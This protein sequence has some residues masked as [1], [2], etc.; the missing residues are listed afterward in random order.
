VAVV[1]GP[2]GHGQ[3][4]QLALR[5]RGV[6]RTAATQE[7]TIVLPRWI[8]HERL[9]LCSDGRKPEDSFF[10]LYLADCPVRS[11]HLAGAVHLSD[12]VAKGFRVGLRSIHDGKAFF[13]LL[14]TFV[15]QLAD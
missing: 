15:E 13:D 1:L 12:E 11:V 7:Q 6:I 4:E 8:N 2:I 10:I 5:H 9:E 3:L 14:V